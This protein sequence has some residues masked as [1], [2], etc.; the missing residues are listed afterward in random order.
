MWLEN[1]RN[2]DTIEYNNMCWLQFISQQNYI[3]TCYAKHTPMTHLRADRGRSR[4]TTVALGPL[5][6][7]SDNN[8]L[9]WKSKWH[10]QCTAQLSKL[11]VQVLTSTCTETWTEGNI[12]AISYKAGTC[13][14]TFYI[15]CNITLYQ[16]L[17]M[18][19]HRSALTTTKTTITAA[20]RRKPTVPTMAN[21]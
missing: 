9:R 16:S 2:E 10:I 18:C 8:N 7:Y 6:Q 20:S 21:T 13:T 1:S 3:L 19:T 5:H 4:N 14:C 12:H 17:S 15:R 11:T